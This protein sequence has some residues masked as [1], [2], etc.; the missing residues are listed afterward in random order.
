VVGI[1]SGMGSDIRF[2]ISAEVVYST[3]SSEVIDVVATKS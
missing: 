2:E 1:F 3:K